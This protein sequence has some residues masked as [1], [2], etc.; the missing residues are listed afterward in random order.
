LGGI[1]E[2][3]YT[4][5]EERALFEVY[6]ADRL[7]GTVLVTNALE[8]HTKLVLSACDLQEAEENCTLE[9]VAVKVLD[10]PIFSKLMLVH[11]LDKG[12]GLED[13]A[14]DLDLLGLLDEAV[15]RAAHGGGGHSVRT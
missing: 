1:L 3:E 8:E 5:H 7:V 9:S 2:F 14:E 6:R 15:Q 10:L 12:L 4:L 11:E 13:V